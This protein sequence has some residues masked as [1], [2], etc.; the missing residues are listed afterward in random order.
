MNI[1]PIIGLLILVSGIWLGGA[2]LRWRR[3]RTLALSRERG[4]QGERDAQAW[5]TTHGFTE[6]DSQTERS[7]SYLVDGEERFFKVRPDFTARHKGE[8]WVIE[9]KTGKSAAPTHRGTRRQV[10]EYAQLFPGR[11][12]GL[13]DASIGKLY[14][15]SFEVSSSVE[16]PRDASH[17][18]QAL[19]SRSLFVLGSICGVVVGWLARGL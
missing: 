10:R 7:F 1:Y 12:Y 9:V 19:T 14:E 5:L 13:F 18:S 11:R 16:A 3:R 6:L 2:Y 8:R 15:V 4:A 17:V